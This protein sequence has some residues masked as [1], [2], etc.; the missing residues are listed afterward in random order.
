M[1]RVYISV[2]TVAALVALASAA[3]A[4]G[5]PSGGSAAAPAPVVYKLAAIGDSGQSGTVT[6]TPGPTTDG[7]PSTIVVIQLTGEPAD[8]VEPAHIHKTP[9]PGTLTSVVYGLTSVQDGKSTTTVPASIDTFAS[10]FS[11]NVHKSK[12]EIKT[13]I[14]C[15]N[16]QQQ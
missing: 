13:Y 10:G 7:K 14:A 4:G 16:L 8:A 6:L 1:S 9:C 15:G 3:F 5:S 2:T 11:V 12:A